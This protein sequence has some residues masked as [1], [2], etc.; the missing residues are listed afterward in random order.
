M[1]NL[2]C[3]GG[4]VSAVPREIKIFRNKYIYVERQHYLHSV[5]YACFHE[6]I[7]LMKKFLTGGLLVKHRSYYYRYY[8]YNQ[9]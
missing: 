2:V 1:K 7:S 8:A 9:K 6:R 3:V 4:G 5:K